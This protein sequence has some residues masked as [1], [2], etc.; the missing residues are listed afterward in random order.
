MELG[1]DRE[2]RAVRIPRDRFEAWAETIYPEEPYSFARLVALSG[3]SR[4]TM[5]HQRS[6]G[7]LDANVV[8]VIAR[9]L[10]RNP[11]AELLR[12]DEFATL[13]RCTDPSTA[14]VLSQLPTANL[15]EELLGRFYGAS[16]AHDP[17][18]MPEINALNRW[19]ATYNLRGR[20]EELAGVVG[21]S[22][23]PEFSRKLTEN[24][25]TLGQ[26]I[27]LSAHAELN[28][29]FSLVVSG[30]VT[31]EE[32]GYPFNLREQTLA[33]ADTD[34]VIAELRR[35]LPW[36]AKEMK[37]RAQPAPTANSA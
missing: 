20:Y 10:G 8:L 18:L 21:V 36:F 23:Q 35:A 29:R 26:L 9:K 14:E 4:S 6:Q 13:S 12:F 7:Y 33:T 2:G 3:L 1:P 17:G 15:M 22:S 37:A 25:F 27:A 34:D 28:A 16:V 32:A 31:F 5:F 19:L 30:I 11:I 24:R